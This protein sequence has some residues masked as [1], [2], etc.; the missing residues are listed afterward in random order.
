M[1]DVKGSKEDG[2]R[3]LLNSLVKVNKLMPPPV[4]IE[5]GFV[6]RF[7]NQYNAIVSTLSST[8]S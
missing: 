2:E 8:S 7:Y 1:D 4:I 6:D 5:Q 3:E